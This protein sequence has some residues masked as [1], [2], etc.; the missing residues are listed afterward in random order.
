MFLKFKKRNNEISFVS[1]L[2]LF[3]SFLIISLFIFYPIVDSFLL[4]LYSWNGMDPVKTFIGFNN[5]KNLI[6]DLRFWGSLKNNIIILVLSIMIQIPMGIFLALA[7]DYVGKRFNFLRSIYYL[8]MLISSVAIGF[9]FRYAYDPQ[10]GIVAGILNI[11][12]I[13]VPIDI[14]GNPKYSIFAIIGVIC[15][16]FIPF[17]FILF[18]A[19]ISSV[20]VELYEAAKIDGAKYRE[21][22][23]KIVIP[24]IS[25]TIKSGIIL[26]MVGSLKY[27]DLIYVMTEGGPNGATEL[28]ATYMY[29][30]SFVTQRL[31]YGATIAFAMLIIISI[32]SFFTFKKLNIEEK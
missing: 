4:S 31:G 25:G 10:F 7:L 19:A 22:A 9:L 5:W 26:S 24:Y 32:I 30:N 21:Y 28:M 8:P 15:W 29:K 14:L 12:K 18:V 16:Q 1:I 6:F 11:F 20:P 23:I 3:P 2:F 17:Y 13:T 27:F